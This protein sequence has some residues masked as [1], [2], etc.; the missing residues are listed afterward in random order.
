MDWHGS[1]CR[2][3][4]LAQQSLPELDHSHRG[5]RDCPPK[6]KYRILPGWWAGT[7]VQTYQSSTRVSPG[8]GVLQGRFMEASVAE[9]EGWRASRPLLRTPGALSRSAGPPGLR[10]DAWPRLDMV[11]RR[12][13]AFCL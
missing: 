1:L 11:N 6:A 8:P 4:E 3:Q 7:K 12:Q 5:P 2:V 9:Q 13:V 10:L